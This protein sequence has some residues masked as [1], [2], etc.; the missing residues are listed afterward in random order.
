MV[1]DMELGSGAFDPQAVNRNKTRGIAI[2]EI[3][4][5]NTPKVEL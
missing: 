3:F 2:L 4:I 5:I 1:G